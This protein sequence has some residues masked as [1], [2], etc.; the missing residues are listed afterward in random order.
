MKRGILFLLILGAI[1]YL[2]NAFFLSSVQ[3]VTSGH[4]TIQPTPPDKHATIIPGDY[5]AVARQAAI[6]ARLDPACFVRQIN[7]ESGFN[8]AALSPAGAIGIAQFMP[9]TAAGL[10][11][12]PHDPIASLHAA[13]HLMASY[14]HQYGSLRLALAAYNAGPATV[15]YALWKGGPS[16]WLAWVPA[17]TQ[18]YVSIIVG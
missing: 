10:G 8:P 4:L 16:H 7:Q 9:A 5:V 15:S 14:V 11:F 1:I 12:D 2:Y 17:E 3:A 13:A 6:E 18:H